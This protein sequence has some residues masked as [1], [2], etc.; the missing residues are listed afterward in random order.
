MDN[1]IVIFNNTEKIET[2]ENI[3]VLGTYN[4]IENAEKFTELEY[5][6]YALF[7]ILLIKTFL[8]QP[9]FFVIFI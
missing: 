8:D 9:N 3:T 5:F 2:S 1:F 6:S 7:S 4:T